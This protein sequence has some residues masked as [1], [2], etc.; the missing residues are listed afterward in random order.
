M[1]L[2]METIDDFFKEGFKP[3]FKAYTGQEQ[4]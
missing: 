3:G 1:V 4:D 2:T